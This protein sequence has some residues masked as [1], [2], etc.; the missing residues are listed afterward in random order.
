ME[1]G[2]C[3]GVGTPAQ[4]GVY[5]EREREEQI[6][7]PAHGRGKFVVFRL[8]CFVGHASFSKKTLTYMGVW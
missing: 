3:P 7:Q 1:M 5:R 4:G 6:E 2:A 8:G